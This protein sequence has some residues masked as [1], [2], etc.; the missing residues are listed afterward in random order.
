MS[1]SEQPKRKRGRPRGTT[2]TEKVRVT[3]MLLPATKERLDAVA[4]RT[5]TTRGEY[6][7]QAL[8]AKFRRGGIA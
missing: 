4:E 7:D 5:E 2:K 3:I 6:V 8:Q 1:N